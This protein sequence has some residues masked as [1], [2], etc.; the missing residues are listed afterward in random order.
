MFSSHGKTLFNLT[1]LLVTY[2]EQRLNNAREYWWNIN[3]SAYVNS[4]EI[5]SLNYITVQNNS[6]DF[7]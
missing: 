3:S 2:Y 4:P 7:H 1:W 6:Q 5:A